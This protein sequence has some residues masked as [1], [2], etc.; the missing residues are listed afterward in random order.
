MNGKPPFDKNE[1]PLFVVIEEKD[2]NFRCTGIGVPTSFGRML[3]SGELVRMF[4]A[5][6]RHV[7]DEQNS[8]DK[9]EAA[10]QVDPEKE[11]LKWLTEFLEKLPKP[12]EKDAWN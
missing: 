9:A 5:G 12:T 6:I 10:S 7:V 8:H 4:I 3:S 1:H 2:G 11:K